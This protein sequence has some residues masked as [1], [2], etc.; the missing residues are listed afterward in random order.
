MAPHGRELMSEITSEDA[1]AVLNTV[2]GFAKKAENVVNS[3]HSLAKSIQAMNDNGTLQLFLDAMKTTN[4]SDTTEEGER[5]EKTRA[6]TLSAMSSEAEGNNPTA[7][8]R[9]SDI[10]NPNEERISK[11]EAR[12][13]RRELRRQRKREKYST[14][15]LY[16]QPKQTV[17]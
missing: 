6:G 12:R 2:S 8:Q 1:M 16:G 9:S 10:S 7:D 15:E 11:R 17:W 5:E 13:R 14:E 4:R 3:V